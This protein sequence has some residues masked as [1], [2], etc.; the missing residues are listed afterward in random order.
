MQTILPRSGEGTKQ[1]SQIEL[2]VL[3][4]KPAG[5]RESG[6]CARWPAASW[7]GSGGAEYGAER[8]SHPTFDHARHGFDLPTLPVST[9]SRITS[10]VSA[11][12]PAIRRRRRFFGGSSDGR[13]DDRA[14]VQFVAAE[15]VHPL[16][17]VPGIGKERIDSL[18]RAARQERWNHARLVGRRPARR[19]G[20]E[21]QVTGAVDQQTALGEV[22]IGHVLQAFVAARAT[23][24]EV[25][26]HVVCREA[27][28][29]ERPFARTASEDSDS[30]SRVQR[31]IQEPVCGVF[32][33]R[34][35]AAFCNVVQCGTVV[36]SITA[37]RS[38]VSRSSC[39][40]PR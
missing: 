32:F 26:A 4:R 6:R 17:V 33:S 27:D 16:A 11:H 12:R 35:S 40:T 29:V 39:Q 20:G 10:E 34:R 3:C 19:M 28:A 30:A 24:D 15:F 37:H 14:H 8:F 38:D 7:S 2:L 1:A 31:L 21:D 23:S 18:S 5:R 9:V 22:P 36:S 25:M 13:R